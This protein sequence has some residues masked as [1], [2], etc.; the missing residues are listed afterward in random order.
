MKKLISD[1]KVELKELAT[2]IKSCKQDKDRFS[3]RGFKETYRA[4]HII[5]CMLRGRTLDQIENHRLTNPTHY[6]NQT[7]RYLK[8]EVRQIWKEKTG[9][10]FSYWTDISNYAQEKRDEALRTDQ[11]I[12]V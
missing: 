8:L 7:E 1:L 11:R 5:R 9:L 3:A 10:T 4:K 2:L 12:A 6:E